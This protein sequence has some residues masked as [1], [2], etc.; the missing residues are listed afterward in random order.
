MRRRGAWRRG[1]AKKA[2]A[3]LRPLV[4]EFMTRPVVVAPGTR[5]E[6]VKAERHIGR[7]S[8]HRRAWLVDRLAAGDDV[9][10]CQFG[11]DSEPEVVVLG[12]LFEFEVPTKGA[13]R[14]RQLRSGS[15]GRSRYINRRAW[16]WSRC[17][18]TRKNPSTTAR[19][20]RRC[21]ATTLEGLTL[22]SPIQPKHLKCDHRAVAV[23]KY[24]DKGP[25]KRLPKEPPRC[26]DVGQ[27]RPPVGPVDAGAAAP[28]AARPPPRCSS[29]T[30]FAGHTIVFTG[31][32]VHLGKTVGGLRGAARRCHPEIGFKNTTL[33][34]EC[35]ETNAP[36]RPTREAEKSKDR[37]QR[38]CCPNPARARS[39]GTT[40]KRNGGLSPLARRRR[41]G[42]VRRRRREYARFVTR[43]S[44]GSSSAF[45]HDRDHTLRRACRNLFRL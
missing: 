10:V 13:A 29:T 6:Y 15:P 7:R 43:F 3:T 1:D 2:Q 33:L 36:G 34:V 11:G 12:E 31:E 38:S 45:D 30:Y 19:C 4:E 35:S 21:R 20:T 5:D 39:S 18:S 44:N 40:S 37:G 22:V 24:L 23:V 17:G 25:L 42:G 28:E 14:R 41:E 8:C 9:P 27:R 26:H 16:A 32:P